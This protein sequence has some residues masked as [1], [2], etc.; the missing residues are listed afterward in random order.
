LAR[1]TN[2]KQ[3]C[4]AADLSSG[5]IRTRSAD[6]SETRKKRLNSPGVFQVPVPGYCVARGRR[7]AAFSSR[8]CRQC[9]EYPRRVDRGTDYQVAATENAACILRCSSLSLSFSLS[10]WRRAAR[11]FPRYRETRSGRF[12]TVVPSGSYRLAY[13]EEGERARAKRIREVGEEGREG[14]MQQVVR[15]SKPIEIDGFPIP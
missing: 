6:L 4:S 10:L 1:A 2:R 9:S 5:L 3:R 14:H 11:I 15:F 7:R 8:T 13:R 12:A